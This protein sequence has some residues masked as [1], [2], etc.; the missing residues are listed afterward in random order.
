MDFN[1]IDRDRIAWVKPRFPTRL[2][3]QAIDEYAAEVGGHV[4]VE[5]VEKTG[6]IGYST[7]R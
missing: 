4:L 1:V 2:L 5:D 6:C 3:E 7:V